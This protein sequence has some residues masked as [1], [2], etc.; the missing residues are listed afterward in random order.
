MRFAID[1]LLLRDSQRLPTNLPTLQ[2]NPSEEG[3]TID[4][5]RKP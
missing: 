2:D 4:Y 3:A 1:S 5:K